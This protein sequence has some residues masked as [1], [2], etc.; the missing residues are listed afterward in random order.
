RTASTLNSGPNARRVR[1][2]SSF[3]DLVIEHL[4]P[5]HNGANEV[6]TKSGQSH[7]Y[8]DMYFGYGLITAGVCLVE[9]VLL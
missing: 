1:G 8:W 9:A 6:P 5:E 7:S 2:D 3:F 4:H